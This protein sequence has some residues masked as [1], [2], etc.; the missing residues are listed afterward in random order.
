MFG[1]GV[2][3]YLDV[4]CSMFD[5]HL[6]KTAQYDINATCERLQNNLAAYGDYIMDENIKKGI[7]RLAEML[8]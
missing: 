6:Y 2:F 3:A 4:R 7:K 1:I 5:V 8:K